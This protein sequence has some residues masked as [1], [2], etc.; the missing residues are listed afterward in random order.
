MAADVDALNYPYIRVRDVDWLK[1]TLLIFPHVVRMMPRYNAPQDDPEVAEF[2][3]LEGRRGPLLRP[4]DLSNRHIRAAQTKLI[5]DINGHLDTD[6][7][8]FRARFGREAAEA[9]LDELTPTT[10]IWER[11][12]SGRVTFQ[13]HTRKILEELGHFLVRERLAWTPAIPDDDG[14]YSHGSEY[15]EMH[16]RLGEAV[17]ATLAFAC[18]ENEGLEV[19]TEFPGIHGNILERPDD[20]F[21]ACLSEKQPADAD[22]AEQAT[23]FLVY[24]RCDP[25]KLTAK[26]LQALNKEWEALSN[27]REAIEA[28][29][30]RIPKKIVDPKILEER[31]NDVANDVFK[32]WKSDQANLSNYVRE[33]FGEGSLSE[34]E[35]LLQKLA[36]KAAGPTVAGALTGE[37]TVGALTGAAAG[38]A[39]GLMSHGIATFGKI[40]KTARNSPVRYLTMLEKN[41]VGFT[42]GV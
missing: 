25:T 9:E 27:F 17:M 1:R 41:G 28:A 39:I 2:C 35:K 19:V 18:A 8:S 16:R 42:V 37:L 3:T 12:L 24:R 21:E 13:V 23:Q 34:P 10:P 11:R 4:A 33:L 20:V 5:E 36:E 14:Y 38:F 6:G 32:K 26:R 7:Q 15:I 22:R 30:M 40:R 29:A 31:L